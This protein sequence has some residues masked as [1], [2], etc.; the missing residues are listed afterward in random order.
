MAKI[1][2]VSAPA[3][4]IEKQGKPYPYDKFR[5]NGSL[6]DIPVVTTKIKPINKEDA[7]SEIEKGEIVLDPETGALH[8]ALGKPHSQGGTSV[9]LKD[10]SFIFS[11]FKDLAIND[12]QKELFNFKIGGKKDKDNTPAKVLGKEVDLKHHNKMAEIIQNEKKY[13]GITNNSAAL[14]MMKNLE[15]AGQVAFLQESK[16]NLPVPAFGQN[17]APVFSKDVD[18]KITQAMQYLKKG[19][20]KESPYYQLGGFGRAIQE[21][22]KKKNSEGNFYVYGP[23]GEIL[24]EMD[25]NGNLVKDFGVQLPPNATTPKPRIHARDRSYN[26]PPYPNNW[27]NYNDRT[28]KQNYTAPDWIDPKTFYST[29]GLI[30]YMKTLNDRPGIDNDMGKADDSHWGWR[31]QAALEKF[32]P[33]NTP[34]EKPS[35]TREVPGQTR[36]SITSPKP[37]I[38]LGNGND[39]GKADGITDPKTY[40]TKIPI[41]QQLTMLRP[42]Y[43]AAKVKTQ[44][45]LRQHQES[46]IPQFENQNVQPQLN[47]NNQAYFNAAN[48]TRT[49]NPN[50]A[51]SYL[52]Q[53]YGNRINANDQAIGNV[54]NNNIQIQNRQKELAASTLNADASANRAFDSRFFDQTNMAIRNAEN[55]K[56]AYTTQGIQGV[57]DVMSKKL[58]FDSWLNSQ[59]QFRGKPTYKDKDGVQHYEGQ[60][61]Y[62]PK[63]GFFGY[64][65]QHNPTNVDWS[66]YQSTNSKID[67]P[68]ELIGLYNRLKEVDPNFKM[69]DLVRFKALQS[70]NTTA[71][72]IPVQKKGGKY[73]PKLRPKI[74]YY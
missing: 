3:D 60:T 37:T 32:F 25:A 30:D 70:Y 62:S 72:G 50:Q 40:N 46:V 16:K 8:K 27:V 54:Q 14:M 36:V 58:A 12:K 63:A 66:T 15:K 10:N 38:D 44:Y 69:A 26:E 34:V 17:T 35:T 48:L 57:N 7:N 49:M 73:V 41:W 47:A 1:K 43:M 71:N 65:I 45:P 19:G 22:N 51:S 11:N 68:E 23:Q 9:N 2:I 13:D 28:N 6:P 53:L 21:M 5:G 56:E 67:S 61:L 4:Y 33:N 29:P 64:S 74:N 59:Q 42:F 31:H 18:D 24:K 55:L 39:P 52:Q 20:I